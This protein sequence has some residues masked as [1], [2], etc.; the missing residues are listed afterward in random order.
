MM[1]QPLDIDGVIETNSG[2]ISAQDLSKFLYYF[3]AAYVEAL[4][5]KKEGQIFD[6]IS[7]AELQDFADEVAFRMGANGFPGASYNANAWLPDEQDLNL[8]DI[9]RRNPLDVVFSCVGVALAAAVII[10]G[11]EIKW[12]D[13]GFK[14]KLPPLGKGIAELRKAIAT[15]PQQVTRRNTKKD[16]SSSA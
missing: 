9:S 1:H 11:G 6:H 3:R 13:K 16:D 4:N 14:V 2:P 10:S 7:K 15:K 8:A 12:D 5:Y